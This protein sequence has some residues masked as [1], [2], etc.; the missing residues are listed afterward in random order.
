M[1]EMQIYQQLHYHLNF[2]AGASR[3]EMI[4]A[5]KKSLSSGRLD[6]EISQICQEHAMI[7]RV[8]RNRGL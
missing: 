8:K 7:N 2:A 3:F 4:Q 1:Y 6:V 5:K